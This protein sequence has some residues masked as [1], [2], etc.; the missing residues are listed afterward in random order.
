MRGTVLKIESL[1]VRFMVMWV[2]LFILVL[3]PR[4]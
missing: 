3:Y 1:N 4:M 2:L